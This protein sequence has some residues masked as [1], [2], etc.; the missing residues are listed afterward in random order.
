MRRIFLTSPAK[1]STLWFALLRPGRFV[2]ISSIAVLED[3]AG[4]EDEGTTVFQEELAYGRHCLALE[5][6]VE[7]TFE[8]SLVARLPALFGR[9]LQK[10]FIFDLLNSIPT[11]LAR[12]LNRKCATC[13]FMNYTNLT[14]GPATRL[15]RWPQLVAQQSARQLHC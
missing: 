8:D 6:C 5:A 1:S 15:E 11:K 13:K 3:F 10:N 2:L 9:G 12:R 14:D 7:E 4:G